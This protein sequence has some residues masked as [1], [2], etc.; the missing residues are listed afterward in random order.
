MRSLLLLTYAI[1]LVN[2]KNA[3]GR[4]TEWSDKLQEAI[5]AANNKFRRSTGYSTFR[6][7]FGMFRPLWPLKLLT[8][9]TVGSIFNND[10]SC[11]AELTLSN[12]CVYL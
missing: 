12:S 1:P 3:N 11:D 5:F 4:D 7:I 10:D 6:T 2:L 8:C 9:A